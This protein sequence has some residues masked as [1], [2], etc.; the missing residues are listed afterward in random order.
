[1][2][3]LDEGT[4]AWRPVDALPL[5]NSMYRIVS[6]NQCPEIEKWQFDPGTIVK[7]ESRELSD[8]SSLVAVSQAT[9]DYS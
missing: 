7:C 3:L 4:D 6:R 5:G 8:G 2:Y 1:V 9:D